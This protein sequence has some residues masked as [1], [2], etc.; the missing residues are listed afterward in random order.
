MNEAS[1]R[2]DA[3]R[4]EVVTPPEPPPVAP[5][6][7]ELLHSRA[8]L[9]LLI[10]TALLG[11]PISVGAYLFL[12]VVNSLQGW[13]FTDLPPQLG[14]DAAA[15]AGLGF[16][17]VLGPEAPLIALGA[18]AAVAATRLLPRPLPAQGLA[19]V[20]VAGSFAAIS[21]LL[22]SP[23][24]GAFLLMEAAGLGGAMMGP[25][26][27]PGLLSAGIGGLI[28]G[29]LAVA[30]A[31][32]TDHA[33][34]DVLYSGESQLGP[35]L[36]GAA[37]YSAWALLLLLAAKGLAYA[38]A[39]SSFRGGPVFPAMFLGAGGGIAL[40]HLPGLPMLTGAA[41]GIGAM[42][43]AMLRLPLTS[44]LLATLLLSG[45]GVAVMPLVIVAVVVSHVATAWLEWVATA[46]RAGRH[47]VADLSSR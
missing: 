10:L 27:V 11:V 3:E 43:V 23:L 6:P 40:S 29:G 34:S 8:Y 17:V 46:S 36:A 24:L 47:E 7:A 2:S 44:V 30:Y 31:L 39:L 1:R 45:S 20:G 12:P 13:A 19:V 21:A 33:S 22:G 28:I 32:L 15:L 37:G 5:D 42:C 38:L 25:V 26:L 4:G 18:G 14:F 35:L 41:M 16:G 9:N